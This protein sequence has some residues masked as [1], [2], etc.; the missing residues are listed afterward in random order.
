M[1]LRYLLLLTAL[2][3][4][5][6]PD[7][8]AQVTD[9]PAAIDYQGKVLD[10]A[11]LPLA[12]PTPGN[13]P[14]PKNYTMYFRIYDSPIG[15]NIIWS[16]SQV[17]TVSNG[18]FSVRIGEGNPVPIT[19]G[20]NEGTVAH[21]DLTKAFDD[22]SRYLGLTVNIPPQPLV[23]ITPR[24]AFLAAPFSMVAQHAVLA[25]TATNAALAEAVSQTTGNSA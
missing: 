12:G 16:E 22:K 10:S 17:V 14:A 25:D 18:L 13:S 3:F 24:L 1:K 20:V 7:L 6:A 2:S 11:G 8:G 23:E 4:F 15:G 9:A 21:S 5:A 19:G